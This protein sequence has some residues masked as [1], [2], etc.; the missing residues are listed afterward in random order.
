MFAHLFNCDLYTPRS[1]PFYPCLGIIF[2]FFFYLLS[3]YIF[4][5]VVHLLFL[6]MAC[7]T[8]IVVWVHR[9]LSSSLALGRGNHKHSSKHWVYRLID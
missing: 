6:R 8:Y 7:S 5:N 1:Y 3:D 9:L 4:D 2:V